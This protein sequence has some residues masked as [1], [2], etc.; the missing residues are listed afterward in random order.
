MLQIKGIVDAFETHVS[1][2]DDEYC[3]AAISFAEP[4]DHERIKTEIQNDQNIKLVKTL[5]P[6]QV[7]F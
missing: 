4:A 3:I 5:N 2:D 1:L 6:E 7:P